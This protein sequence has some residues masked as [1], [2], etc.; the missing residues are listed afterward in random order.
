MNAVRMQTEKWF[1][2]F[3]LTCVRFMVQFVSKQSK[4]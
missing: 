2:S 4:K 1:Q 3:E